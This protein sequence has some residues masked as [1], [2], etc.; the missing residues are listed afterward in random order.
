LTI[1]DYRLRL[2][3]RAEAQ[4]RLAALAPLADALIA[5]SCPGPAPLGLGST[6]NAIFNAATSMLHCPAVTVPILAVDNMPV[7]VQVVGQRHMDARVAG[8]ARWLLESVDP[9]IAN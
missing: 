6:G 1:E 4:N 2:L 7:G 5:L 8:I 9:V 3:Q